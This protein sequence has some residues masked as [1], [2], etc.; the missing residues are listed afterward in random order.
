M[1]LLEWLF[2]PHRRPNTNPVALPLEPDDPEELHILAE[3]RLPRT[4]RRNRTP[5]QIAEDEAAQVADLRRRS[6]AAFHLTSKRAAAVGSE[7]YKWRSAGDAAVCTTCAAR[8]GKTFRWDQEPLNGHAG[9]CEACPQGHCRC[10]AE[11]II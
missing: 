7:T 6:A 8:N 11:P 1:K 4:R 10:L 2:R 5:E 3:P 9:L